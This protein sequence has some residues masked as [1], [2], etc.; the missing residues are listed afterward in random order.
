MRAAAGSLSEGT[1]HTS[2]LIHTPVC[3]SIPYLHMSA[4]AELDVDPS[5]SSGERYQVVAAWG[6][7]IGV[8]WGSSLIRPGQPESSGG[9][10]GAG[11]LIHSPTHPVAHLW[12][13]AA[14]AGEAHSPR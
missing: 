1:V 7:G 6:Q 4:A 12:A 5:S 13:E 14:N 2:P 8:H 9:R 10:A 11:E 3:T